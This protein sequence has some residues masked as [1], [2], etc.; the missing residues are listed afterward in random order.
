MPPAGIIVAGI[1]IPQALLVGIALSVTLP[2]I[3][4]SHR[5]AFLSKA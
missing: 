5:L 2:L 1:V 4:L 3:E